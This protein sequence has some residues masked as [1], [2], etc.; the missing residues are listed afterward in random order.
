MRPKINFFA[1]VLALAMLL[2]SCVQRF[3]HAD[4]QT[5]FE[6]QSEISSEYIDTNIT[7]TENTDESYD[8]VETSDPETSEPETSDPETS[9]PE[10]S[11]PE[12]TEPESSETDIFDERHMI[13]RSREELEAMLTVTEEDFS[14]ADRLLTSYEF[15]SIY[16]SDINAIQKAYSL[17]SASI[18]HIRSQVSIASLIYYMDKSDISAY[19]RYIGLYED[20]G[21]LTDRY[22][23]C[24]RNIYLSSPMRD[25]LFAGWPEHDIEDILD[26][27]GEINE[28]K[29]SNKELKNQLDEL[30]GE[31]YSDG[32]AEIYVRLAQNCNRIAEIE[33]YESYY[34][35]AS[36]EI[37]HRDYGAAEL[38]GFSAAVAEIYIPLFEQLNSMLESRLDKLD[39]DDLSAL[40]SFVSDPFDS[41]DR[42][43]LYGYISSLD[44]GM[45][46]GMQHAFLNRNI[47]FAG[48]ADSHSTAV[49]MYIYDLKSPFCLFGSRTQ[50]TSA[51]VH[52]LGHYYG[53]LYSRV[54]SYD[55]AEVQSQGNEML[56]LAYLQ[57]EMDGELF[58]ALEL[59]VLCTNLRL[60]AI[61][62]IVDEFEREV[63]SLDSVDGFTSVE[64]DAIMS[65]VCEKYGGIDHIN[66]IFDIDMN[67]YW[68]KVGI[69]NPV[70]YISYA[71][72]MV[73][74]L[75][76]YSVLKEDAA[77]G[78]EIYRAL[79]EDVQ[80]N[81]FLL[82]ALE[83][84][85][86]LSPFDECIAERITSIIPL[87]KN[88]DTTAFQLHE[89]QLYFVHY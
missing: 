22:A 6:P 2:S 47:V 27:S 65:K 5:E 21:K 81:E 44:G 10:T 54:S 58:S 85:G 40:E 83:N 59:Q 69:N 4:N 3:G 46:D 66:S 74:A 28:L 29:T 60:M 86:L 61:C 19:E 56:L 37:Y 49:Q 72:S 1:L 32:A 68:R 77:Q 39:N 41:L 78:R 25:E 17:F 64:L 20:S 52:E 67:R 48:S 36:K 75:N 33:G 62:T 45:R 80:K 50:Y 15:L 38:D 89:M 24:Q 13:S 57:G 53:S 42:N 35:Y 7:D 51:V 16:G 63:Y 34:D 14:E 70:Y 84:V 23:E 79:V 73:S 8:V 87:N 71:I 76:I 9:E 12:T 18:R 43:Y 88:N 30:S 31:E 55:L 26:H 82:T 11:D